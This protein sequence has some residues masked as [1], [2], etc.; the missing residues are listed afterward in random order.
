MPK[1]TGAEKL[2]VVI[3]AEGLGETA[4]GVLVHREGRHATQL[5]EWRTAA[6]TALGICA[7]RAKPGPSVE[8]P[9]IQALE[10]ELRRKDVALAETAALLVLKKSSGNLGESGRCHGPDAGTVIRTLI[11]EAGAH[12]DDAREGLHH[13]PANARSMAKCAVFLETVKSAT[14]G[15]LSPHHIAP[16]RAD[17][18]GHLASAS[19]LYRVLR[20]DALLTHRGRSAACSGLS[21]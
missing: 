10:R 5:A 18:G 20:T 2:R 1:W 21:S 19:T 3:A 15:D 14:Y 6:E 13:V 7:S 8:T 11:D 9:R 17:A 4:L 12:P 16:R